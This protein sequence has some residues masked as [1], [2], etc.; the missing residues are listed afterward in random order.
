MDAYVIFCPAILPRGALH[1]ATN[2][3][4]LNFFS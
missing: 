3:K 2:E 4:M 1:G